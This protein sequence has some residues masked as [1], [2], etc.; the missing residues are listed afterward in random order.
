ME[1]GIAECMP[2]YSGGL[3]V[4]S[5]DHLKASSDAEIP[6]VAVGLLY[7][8]GYL[9]QIAESGRLATGAESS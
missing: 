4:L 1:Y 8:K 3:G 5:G 2:I 7:Q 9:Q 6:L